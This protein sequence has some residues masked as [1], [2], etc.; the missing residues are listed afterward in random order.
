MR[1]PEYYE[2]EYAQIRGSA[3]NTHPGTGLGLSLSKHLAEL[4]GGSLQLSSEF[5]KGTELRL[6][7]PADLHRPT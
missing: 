3:H 6:T 4:H 1:V 5:G 7:L 2:R